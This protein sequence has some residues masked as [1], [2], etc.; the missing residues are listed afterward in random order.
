MVSF[1]RVINVN[2]N[3]NNNALE[4]MGFLYACC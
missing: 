4:L 2:N 3:D 1:E